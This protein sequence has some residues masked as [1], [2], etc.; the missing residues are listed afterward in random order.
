MA[1]KDKNK[2]FK[3]YGTGVELDLNPGIQYEGHDD[4]IVIPRENKEH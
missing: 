2:E 4:I 1:G 3:D